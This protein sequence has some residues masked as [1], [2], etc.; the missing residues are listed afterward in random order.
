MSWKFPRAL[1]AGLIASLVGACVLAEDAVSSIDK[2]T[3]QLASKDLPTRREAAFQLLHL[4]AAAKPAL[5]ALL[6]ALDDDDKQ[7]WS[8]AI[9]AIAVIGPD[10]QEAIPTLIERMDSRKGGRGRQRDARQGIMRT[11]YALSR[12]GAP[13]IQPLTEALGQT[14]L[15]LRLGATRALGGIGPAAH[16]AIPA[17]IK[18]LGDSQDPLRDESA[19]AL[20]L[21]GPE[22]GSALVAALKDSDAR[23]RAGAANALALMDPP[24]QAGAKDVEQAATN[25]KDGAV[26]IA[27]FGALPK[28][29]VAPD[30]CVALMLP[31]VT[32]ENEALRHAALNALL[33]VP[34]VRQAA[35]PKLAALL[36]DNNPAIRERAARALGRMGPSAA[37][38]LPTLLQAARTAEG[39]PAYADALAQ[40]GPKALPALLDI[41]QKN[42]P[43]ESKWVLRILHSFGPPAV[44]VLGEALKSNSPE[45]R[46]SAANA[47]AEMGHEADAAAK[48]LF[49]LIKDSSPAVQAAAFGAL[50]AVHADSGRLKPLLQEALGDKSPEVRRAA[51]AGMAALGGAAALGVDGLVDLL[52]DDNPAGRIAAVGALGQLG[53]KAAPAVK[54]LVSRLDDPVLQ[55]SIIDALGHIG[56]AAAPAVP[57]LVEMTKSKKDDQRT[58]ILPVLTGIGPGA[59]EA[60]PMIYEAVRDSAPDVRASAATALAAVE[61]D[62]DKA[63]AVLAPLVRNT[64]SGKVRRVAAHALAKYGPAASAAVPGLITMLEK[65]TERGEAMRALKAIGVKNVPDLLTMLS[66]S[67]PRVKTFACE[68]LGSLGPDAKDAAPKL[69]EIAAQ[70]GAL[71]ASANAALKKIDPSAP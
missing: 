67:D 15:T 56:P 49:V 59:K 40:I 35:V 28:V 3:G 19:Q 16:D 20:A 44:P 48:P 23:R 1:A 46:V 53:D 22:A 5:P 50:V 70:D 54:A 26:R 9:Q 43:E 17:L 4:G 39:A 51:A 55:S 58:S 8:Y 60:L 38:A 63:I 25:E 52:S 34:A 10:A 61:T 14:D 57:R 45:V 37:D 11:A 47:L 6:K 30:R 68:S 65:E 13:A 32:D 2:L 12:I 21:M 24:F 64:E 66:V 69:R 42:K 7:I 27:L 36:K 31:A 29:G 33:G 41:L 71:R 62:N 18:N